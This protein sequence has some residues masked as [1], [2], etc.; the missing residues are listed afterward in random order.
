M[1]LSSSNDYPYI[2][3]FY[4]HKLYIVYINILKASYIKAFDNAAITEQSL[5]SEGEKTKNINCNSNCCTS[6][7]LHFLSKTGTDKVVGWKKKKH[8]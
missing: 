2:N 1:E 5:E 4:L 3:V 7:T 8:G 6:G